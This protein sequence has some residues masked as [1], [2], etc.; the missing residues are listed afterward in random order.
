M[1]QIRP[2]YHFRQEG[3]DLLAWDVRRLIQL[4]KGIKPEDI[5]LTDVPELDEN[6]WFKHELPTPR[7]IAQHAQLIEEADLS[8]PI[9][10]DSAGRVMDGMHRICK[11]LL[12]QHKQVKAVQ[13]VTDPEPDYKNVSPADLPYD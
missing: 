9:I 13:F 10:L 5:L 6:H 11:A 2:Q 3:P 7:R 12:L 8:Y 4:T 1:A